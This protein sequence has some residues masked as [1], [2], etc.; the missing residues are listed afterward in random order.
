VRTLERN[1]TK[2]YRRAGG[3]A[4]LWAAGAALTV[5]ALAVGLTASPGPAYADVTSNSYTIGSPSSAVKDVGVTPGAMPVSAS[6]DFEVSFTVGA[7]L[8][9]SAS[10]SVTVVPSTPL[11]S[12]PTSVDLVGG[13]CIQAGT[14]GGPSSTTGITIVLN[15]SCSLASGTKAEVDFEADAPAATGTFTFAVTTTRNTAPATSNPVTVSTGGAVLTAANSVLGSN[16]VYTVSN[17]SVANLT[18]GGNIINLTAIATHGS[19]TITF[20]NSGSGGTGYTVTYTPAG[21][22][23]TPDT[24][25]SASASGSSVNLTLSTALANGDSFVVTATGTNPTAAGTADEIAVEDGN[26]TSQKTNSINFGGSV[27]GLSVAPSSTLAGATATYGVTFK[28]S[29]SAAAGGDIYLS[30]SAGPTNFSTVTGIEVVDTTQNWHFVATAATLSS[31][32]ATIP[33]TDTINAGD[34][35]N[36]ILA[37][38]TNP[39]AAGSIADFS[40][41]TTGDPVAATAPP[42][43]LAA[44]GSTGVVVTVNPNTAGSVATYTI[45]DLLARAALVG[46]SATIQLAGPSGTTFPNNPSFYTISDATTSS[47]SGTVSAALSGGGTATVTFTLPHTVNSGDTFTVTVADV[48]NPGT[49]SSSDTIQVVNANVSGPNAVPTTTTTRPTTTTT[50]PPVKKPAIS[51]LSSKQVGVSKAGALSIKLK[52]TVKNCDGTVTL[53]DV[54]TKVASAKYSLKEG[55]TGPVVLKL[56]SKGQGFIKGAKKHTISVH[57]TITVTGG[58]TVKTKTALVG[59]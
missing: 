56:N 59:P 58:N 16:T 41:A 44:N 42:Y 25:T 31:G 43:K 1:V 50:R 47:G 14:N 37:G 45:A 20:V 38:V 29:N 34:T 55:K 6:T 12:T 7:A 33:L 10:D 39:S 49:A 26:A 2:R 19:G 46:G 57:V 4:K 8:S 18:S 23:A 40:V 13:S 17:S 9:G 28:A 11:G 22:R 27:S 36:I 30:E 52:C 21:G 51:D 48:I 32:S 53:A 5:G 3:Q 35:V 24:I 15:S 54:T